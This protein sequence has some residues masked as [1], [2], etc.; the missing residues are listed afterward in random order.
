MLLTA[1]PSRAEVGAVPGPGNFPSGDWRVC[2]HVSVVQCSA[3]LCLPVPVLLLLGGDGAAA[4]QG[5][6]RSRLGRA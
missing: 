2:P 3:A 4:L 5:A 6:P 1:E